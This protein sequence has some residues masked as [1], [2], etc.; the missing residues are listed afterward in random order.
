[1]AT[2]G[3]RRPGSAS[4]VYGRRGIQVITRSPGGWLAEGTVGREGLFALG[5]G[6]PVVASVGAAIGTHRIG[7]CRCVQRG[8]DP[9]VMLGVLQEVFRGNPVPGRERVASQAVVT[10]RNLASRSPHLDARAAVAFERLVWT[11]AASSLGPTAMAAG[12]SG[13]FRSV[14]HVGS[15]YSCWVLRMSLLAWSVRE[16]RAFGKTR[17]DRKYAGPFNSNS[18]S[19]DTR[20]NCAYYT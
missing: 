13:R 1:M 6:V 19:T 14:V 9:L 20:T 12:T 8:L 16:A 2:G 7:W 4:L 10:I 15:C 5:P 18:A 17:V 3:G 11:A